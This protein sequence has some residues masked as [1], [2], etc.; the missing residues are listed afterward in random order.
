MLDAHLKQHV[1]CPHCPFSA[2]KRLVVEHERTAHPE[3]ASQF[4]S[5]SAANSKEDD[6]EVYK[7]FVVRI[8]TPEEIERWRAA[9]RKN[10]PTADNVAKKVCKFTELFSSLY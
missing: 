2:A 7:P 1:T 3:Q 8:E 9:R 6:D 4:Q 10:Y 5:A